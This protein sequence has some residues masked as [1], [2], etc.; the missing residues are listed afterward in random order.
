MECP[1]DRP[2]AAAVLQML[3]QELDGLELQAATQ[4]SDVDSLSEGK[5]GLMDAVP[6]DGGV[7][8]SPAN[9]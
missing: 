6:Q 1:E 8:P 9:G 3:Q 5:P 2:T 4:G 7:P